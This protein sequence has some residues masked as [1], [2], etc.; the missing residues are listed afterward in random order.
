[1]GS[2]ARNATSWM[3][4]DENLQEIIQSTHS[5]YAWQLKMAWNVKNWN[6][7]SKKAN[8]T[9]QL[10]DVLDFHESRLIHGR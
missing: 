1:M 7:K 2:V 6:Q 5:V 3:E 8:Q 9:K 4:K 10:T